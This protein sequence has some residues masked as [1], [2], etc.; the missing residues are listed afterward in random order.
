ML[1]AIAAKVGRHVITSGIF[2][3]LSKYS[4]ASVGAG[5]KN[6]ELRSTTDMNAACGPA[7]SESRAAVRSAVNKLPT[8][9]SSCAVA[10]WPA[11]IKKTTKPILLITVIRG[12]L[13]NK[14]RKQF[15]QSNLIPERTIFAVFELNTY[16]IQAFA[17]T[18]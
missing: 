16:G 15:Y 8:F 9:P 18:V 10:A 4:N 1:F 13:I 5:V 14:L 17:Y 2:G 12:G 3:R 11:T 6:V 7:V